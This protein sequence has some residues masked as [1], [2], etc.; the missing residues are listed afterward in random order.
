MSQ[1]FDDAT[2]ILSDD[3]SVHLSLVDRSRF[4]HAS[5]RLSPSKAIGLKAALSSPD[6]EWIEET[7]PVYLGGFRVSYSHET[8]LLQFASSDG[9]FEIDPL[10]EEA[11]AK[12]VRRVKSRTPIPRAAREPILPGLPTPTEEDLARR[13]IF[14]QAGSASG[15]PG[16]R[17]PKP[18]Y[19]AP[20]ASKERS[21]ALIHSA[22][23]DLLLKGL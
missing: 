4:L 15:I 21:K 12:M 3:G 16:Y 17:K 11:F 6:V 5:I 13:T 14:S 22:L 8:G 23:Q 10:E 1:R 18:R 9:T 19:N 7:S 20:R 2:I